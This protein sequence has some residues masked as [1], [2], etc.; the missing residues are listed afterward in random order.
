V[1]PVA[2]VGIGPGPVEHL[3]RQAEFAV[4]VSKMRVNEC[5]ADDDGIRPELLRFLS[6]TYFLNLVG[7]TREAG[8]SGYLLNW[9]WPGGGADCGYLCA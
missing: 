4:L 3:C 7:Q 2:L 8:A 6:W 9:G 5:L 1:Q